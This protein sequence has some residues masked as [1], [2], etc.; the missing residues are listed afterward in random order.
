MEPK[1]P[2]TDDHARHTA[3]LLDLGDVFE[4]DRELR[5]VRVNTAAATR[6]VLR[7]VLDVRTSTPDGRVVAVPP[8]VF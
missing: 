1:T 3:E 5:I 8:L 2:F 7:N 6:A 4:L